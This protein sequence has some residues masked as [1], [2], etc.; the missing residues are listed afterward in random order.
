MEEGHR[1]TQRD[2]EGHRSKSDFLGK[3]VDAI[4][5]WPIQPINFLQL[6]IGI[7]CILDTVIS[8]K[9]NACYGS[10]EHVQLSGGRMGSIFDGNLILQ[11]K[12]VGVCLSFE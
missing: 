5:W 9:P 11:L 10:F 3:P 1:G 4:S 7:H 2:T 8:Y 6:F 12:G